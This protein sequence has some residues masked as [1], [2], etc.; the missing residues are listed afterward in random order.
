MYTRAEVVA[1]GCRRAGAP[2]RRLGL[3]FTIAQRGWE[4]MVGGLIGLLIFIGM[5]ATLI[6]AVMVRRR[7]L[8]FIV[9]TALLGLACIWLLLY[10]DDQLKSV[11]GDTYALYWQFRFLGFNVLFASFFVALFISLSPSTTRY[12]WVTLAVASYILIGAIAGVFFILRDPLLGPKGF[13]N[14]R[15][16]P[17]YFGFALTWPYQFLTVNGFFGLGP[18]PF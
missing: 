4:A 10:M 16:L 18:P 3:E 9:I 17:F 8:G 2:G 11:Q 14:P 5:V 1:G 15:V 6:L 13:E 7:N 12:R